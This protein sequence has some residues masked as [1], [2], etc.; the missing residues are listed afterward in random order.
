MYMTKSRMFW[1][2]IVLTA[3]IATVLPNT[4]AAQSLEARA[5]VGMAAAP[6][7]THIVLSE[8]PMATFAPAAVR[9]VLPRPRNGYSDAEWAQIK[10][11]AATMGAV[12]NPA[13]NRI[14][15][16]PSRSGS[17][18]LSPGA[19]IDVNGANESLACSGL[20][21]SDMGLAVNASYVVQLTNACVEVFNKNGGLI[22]GYPK[23]LNSLFGWAAGTFTFDPRILY[24]WQTGRFIATS[25][26]IS[27]N[28]GYVNVA[29]SQSGNPTGGWYT[30]SFAFGSTGQFGD[31]PTV[32]QTDEGDND[33]GLITI[34]ANIFVIN[35]GFVTAQCD[36]LNKFRMI[37]GGG[38]S[39]NYNFNFSVGGVLVD[40]IQPANQES[41]Y[42]KP[43]AQFMVNSY[44]FTFACNPSCNGLVVW[45]VSN[46]V[47][48]TGSPGPVLSGTVVSTPSSYTF[49][50]NADQP[51]SDNSIDTNDLRISGTVPYA[52]GYLYPTINVAN[53]GT[54]A[55]L[56]WKVATYLNDNGD[57][58]CTGAFLNA[59]PT[60]DSHTAVVQEFCYNCGAGHSNSGYYGSIAVTPGGDWTMTANYSDRNTYPGT[61][62]D[63]NRVTW[64]TPFHDFGNFICDAANPYTQ[65]RWGDYTATAPDNEVKGTGSIYPA[66]WSSGMYVPSNNTWGTCVAASG[67]NQ[68]TQP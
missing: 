54:S 58:H 42:N 45:A 68:P 63:S 64:P 59:C 35:G 51:G 34:C 2:V 48:N 32:G 46:A 47:A 1:A 17:E 30:Y 26:T 6:E 9:G 65:G 15:G 4:I 27:S 31:F 10:A 8:Q 33:N 37:I 5:E 12:A 7:P 56:G 22:T 21:P 3:L 43:R 50:A 41:G 25:A 53:G 20:T 36:Y 44:D 14:A 11:R 19:S 67:Y 61:F 39:Y 55:I 57:G 52:G 49:P 16:A 62:I 24:D 60:V 18:M 38:F 29:V 28:Q 13:I 23:T 40:T 66:S